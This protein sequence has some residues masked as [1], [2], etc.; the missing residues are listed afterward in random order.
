[1]GQPRE[2]C[3]WDIYIYIYIYVHKQME[4]VKTQDM[5]NV[6]TSQTGNVE[7]TKWLSERFQLVAL[8]D[9]CIYTYILAVKHYT[10]AYTAKWIHNRC[11]YKHTCICTFVCSVGAMFYTNIVS[12]PSPTKLFWKQVFRVKKLV[13]RQWGAP[14]SNYLLAMG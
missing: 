1:M 8:E 11:T 9:T 3:K 7:W 5:Y 10:F 13:G 2:T 14:N 6:T 4:S 12:W